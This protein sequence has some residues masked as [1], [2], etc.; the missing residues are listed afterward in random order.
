V[1][2]DAGWLG[3]HYNECEKNLFL[4]YDAELGQNA[5]NLLVQ[6]SLAG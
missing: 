4:Y 2:Q 3:F 6:F 5:E 1:L